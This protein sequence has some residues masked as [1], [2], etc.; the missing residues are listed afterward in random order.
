[1]K[2]KTLLLVVLTGVLLIG[3][4]SVAQA[5]PPTQTE[6]EGQEESVA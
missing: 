3:A 4:L 2:L 1:M 6:E 5:A